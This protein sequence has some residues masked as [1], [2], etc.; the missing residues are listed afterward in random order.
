[1]AA[2]RSVEGSREPHFWKH[3]RTIPWKNTMETI[4]LLLVEIDRLGSNQSEKGNTQF[5]EF[6]MAFNKLE[7]KLTFNRGTVKLIISIV[8]LVKRRH[9][10]NSTIVT[11]H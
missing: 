9:L 11:S 5:H 10:A 3:L 7:K 4:I 6:L 1:M 2:Y 8:L